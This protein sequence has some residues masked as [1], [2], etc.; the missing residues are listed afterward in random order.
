MKTALIT[1]CLIVFSI[2][3]HAQRV[4]QAADS[5]YIQHGGLHQFFFGKNYRRIWAQPVTIPLFKTHFG[6]HQFTPVKTGGGLQT[7]SLHLS[8]EN[9][10]DWVLRSVQKNPSK[11]VKPFWRKTFVRKMVQ[12]QVSGSYPYG[13]LV[14]PT[15]ADALNIDHNHPQLVVIADDS[16]LGKFR[17]QF[18]Q[19]M[20]F[21]EERNPK[22]KTISTEKLF[23]IK[24]SL[25]NIFIDS[26][27]FLKCRLLDIVIGDW[28]RHEDQYRWYAV[29]LHDSVLYKPVPNDRDQVF[30]AI[31]GIVPKSI[32][33]LGFMKY[34]EG[35]HE[36]IRNINGFM[37][38]GFS[39]DK[40]ILPHIS[41][42]EWVRVTGEVMKSL[43]DNTLQQSLQCL[44]TEVSYYNSKLLK[45]M[46][47][48][49]DLLQH[50]LPVYFRHLHLH[51]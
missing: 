11:W 20:C 12:D 2:T 23:H 16:A 9:G 17:N 42:D 19:R 13:A 31:G 26:I 36:N 29:K 7:V 44:P 25:P 15:L 3:I 18:A 8:D 33:R 21:L 22:G 35:F 5:Q 43:N 27:T 32:L 40:K 6:T 34:L 41:Y 24:D 14:V 46:M 47:L 49:R 37:Q 39:L 1:Y 48:R 50:V 28:D 38:R 4:T 45:A 10:E 51:Q 30:F